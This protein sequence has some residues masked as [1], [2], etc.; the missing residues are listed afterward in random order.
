MYVCVYVCMYVCVYVWYKT[1]TVDV[2]LCHACHVKSR[3]MSPSATPATQKWRGVTGVTAAPK[4]VQARH[5]VPSVPRRPRKTTV[6]VRLCHAC[7]VKSRW[8]SPSATPATQKWR[9]VTGV[10]AAPKPVQARHPVPSV[11]RRP[12]KTTVDV[13]LCH[14]CHVKSRWMSPSATPATQKWRGV[15]GVTAAPKPVQA[16]HPVP[17]VPRRPRKTTV[18]VRLCH[19]CHVKSRW[20]SPS[21]TPATQKWR[22]VT[23]VTAAPK[24]VQARHPVPSVPRRPRKTTV[25]VRLC[26]ACHVKS[27][28][29]SPSATPATQ[30]WRG[31][32]G[33]TAAPKPVQA[34][35]PVPSVPRRPRKTTVDVRLCHACHVKSRWMSP[36]ATPATQ[37]WRGVTGV[38]AAP[39]PVQARHPVPSVPRRPR[40]TT[41]D[42]RLCHACHVKS[43]WMSPSATPATQKWRG[44]TG[45]TAAPKPVQARHPVPSLP[46]LPRKTTVDVRLCHACHVKSRW[47]SPSAMPATQKWRGVTGVTA[48]SKP[49]Q[50]R[51]PVPSVPRRPHKTTVDVRLCHACHVKS[52]WMSP[53]ATPATQKWRG[54]TG[55]TAAP[56]PVQARHPVPSVPRRPHKTTVDVT[57]CHAERKCVCVCVCVVCVCVL[58]VVCVCGVCVCVWF[59]VCVCVVCGVCLCVVCA[60][61]LLCVCMLLLC[62][63]MCVVVV[64]VY[65]LLLLLCVYVLLLL[66]VCG[67]EGGRR[68]RRS[69]GYRIK[70]KNPTQRCGEK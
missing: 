68:R 51:H 21:A 25:D 57:F 30:K 55:V 23:G 24:P 67:R 69:P 7:H 4:P 34:R 26:H 62:V 10:T 53:S 70:N 40:K 16:R 15:T 35:H 19:A 45:V 22:G 48:A 13:R 27:R 18:D 11:P 36:S 31:V 33:V 60:C 12:R 5:P 50:A 14:A 9:G 2:R 29:M 20:M 58:C 28:W 65:V 54:V 6:D 39:K 64:C 59:V 41:V 3:W 52:R 38:T 1:P 43:R 46:R 8:M 61:V 66:C 37:K 17:S 44:V 49:V 42:V 63:C 56:K 47:M 32:T